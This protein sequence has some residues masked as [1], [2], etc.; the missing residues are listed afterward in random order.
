MWTSRRK[1]WQGGARKSSESFRNPTLNIPHLR[2]VLA[3]ISTSSQV[4]DARVLLND[5]SPRGLR[6]FCSLPLNPGDEVKVT[7]HHPR[8]VTMRAVITERRAPM[9]QGHIVSDRSYVHR[10][11]AEFVFSSDDERAALAEFVSELAQCHGIRPTAAIG[12]VEF[13]GSF[14]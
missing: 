10:L 2:R 1:S 14:V 12:E 9:R 11:T 7:L 8:P 3:R 6:L 4:I 5:I 13:P